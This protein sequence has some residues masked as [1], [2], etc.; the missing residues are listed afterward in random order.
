MK[1]IFL[2]P[3]DPSKSCH[4]VQSSFAWFAVKNQPAKT[5]FNRTHIIEDVATVVVSPSIDAPLATD[6]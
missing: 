5:T 1:I 3:V 4:P 2:N 6:Q